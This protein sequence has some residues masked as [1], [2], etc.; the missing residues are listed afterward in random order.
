MAWSLP[1]GAGRLT[2][3]H[4]ADGPLGEK[5]MRK[6]RKQIRTQIAH[7]AGTLLRGGAPDHAV[8]TSKT[9]RSL[10]R[11][12]GAAPSS[13][14]LFVRRILTAA[15]LDE[16]IPKLLEMNRDEIA[17]LPGV[18]TGRAHQVVAGAL[19]A[20]AVHGRLRPARARDLPVGAARGRHPRSSRPAQRARL[21][22]AILGGSP[23]ALSTASVYPENTT[24]A[25]DYAERLGYDAVE[26]MVGIDVVSQ[27]IE[28]VRALRD[29]HQVPGLCA[30]TRPAC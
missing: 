5:P 7:D 1:L 29:Y 4:F 27:S 18:S 8:A 3:E 14:G 6:L 16:W 24:H 12:C 2:R 11:I 19:V 22:A 23:F 10:A 30:C 17:E 9:F 26:V 13:E 20:A 28:K 15:D 21:R 25:F